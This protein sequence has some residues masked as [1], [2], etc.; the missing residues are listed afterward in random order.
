[1]DSFFIKWFCG[2]GYLKKKKRGG[3]EGIGG[4]EVA[5]EK[6]SEIRKIRN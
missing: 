6:K 4:V 1:M 3:G 5:A 2:P